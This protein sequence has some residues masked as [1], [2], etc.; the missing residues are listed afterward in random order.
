MR[1]GLKRTPGSLPSRVV[2]V[3]T[4]V[5]VVALGGAGIAYAAGSSGSSTT[6]TTTPTT[7]P[8]PSHGPAT[9]SHRGFGGAGFGGPGFGGPGFGGPGFGGPGVGGGA[10]LHGQYTVA[11]GNGGF[12]T[13][14]VQVG[15]ASAVKSGSITLTSADGYAHTYAVTSSTVV[16]SQ[17]DGIASIAAGDEVNLSALSVKGKD[18]ATTITDTTKLGASRSGFGFGR[19]APQGG[20]G[21]PSAAPTTPTA[22]A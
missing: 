5:G 13:I 14:E 8:T 10:V 11:N 7:A 16:D 20:T 2:M 6:A 22:S 19:R 3:V 21:S 12:Q 17:R 18:T 1:F 4:A 9:K 15:K